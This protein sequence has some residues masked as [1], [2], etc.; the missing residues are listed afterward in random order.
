MNMIIIPGPAE[1]RVKAVSLHYMK[2]LNTHEFDVQC[3]QSVTRKLVYRFMCRLDSQVNHIGLL[4]QSLRIAVYHTYTV[5]GIDY[6]VY[7]VCCWQVYM[8][9]INYY[10]T[11]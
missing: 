6:T 4:S 1:E 10:H 9:H 8:D 7:I 2:V 3:L 5:D 11:C